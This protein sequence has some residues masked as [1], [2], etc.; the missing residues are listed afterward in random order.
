MS[1]GQLL[2]RWLDCD[3][4]WLQGQG[5]ARVGLAGRASTLGAGHADRG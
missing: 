5:G 2:A 1:W 4:S 3:G